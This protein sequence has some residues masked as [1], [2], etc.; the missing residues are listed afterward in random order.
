MGGIG[1]FHKDAR[2]LTLYVTAALKAVRKADT[3]KRFYKVLKDYVEHE[4]GVVADEYGYT[5]DDTSA[6]AKAQEAVKTTS[7]LDY[8]SEETQ[9]QKENKAEEKA[10]AKQAHID[11]SA[12]ER[13][14]QFLAKGL[15][16]SK[17]RKGK[18][19][20]KSLDKRNESEIKKINEEVN[21]FE[22]LIEFLSKQQ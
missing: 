3:V 13:V 11:A 16:D 18:E 8:V 10:L 22:Q 2:K 6:L 5:M 12:K 1:A 4:S 19:D 14:L 7:I 17:A 20:K 21:Y 15:E 9:K